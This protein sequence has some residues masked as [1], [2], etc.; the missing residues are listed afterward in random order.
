MQNEPVEVTIKVTNILEKLG[1][2][3]LIGGSLASTLYGMVRT[4]QDS[5]IITE[6]QPKHIQP[7]VEALEEEFYIDEQMIASAIEHRG[8]FNIIHR[9]TIFKVDVF[10]PPSRPFLTS[11]LRRA[12]KQTFQF[13]TEVSASFATPEDTV[14]AKLE[15]Y[16]LGGEASDRQWRD[17]LGVLKTRHGELDLDYL[18]KWAAEI[19]VKDLLDRILRDES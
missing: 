11:Q 17:I 6:M 1:V 12:Q 3:Y 14:L 2:R 16:R 8:S 7:F 10:T 9:E 19:G 18:H 15:W 4:T 5:D 13:A